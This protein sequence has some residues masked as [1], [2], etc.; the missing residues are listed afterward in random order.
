MIVL[1]YPTSFDAIAGWATENRILLREARIRFAQYGVLRAIGAS[2]QLRQALVFK[3][4]NALDF[5]WHAY[6]STRDLDFSVD[7]DALATP[8]DAHSLGEFL[9][10]GLRLVQ[11]DLGIAFKIHRV[12]KQPPGEGATFVTFEAKVGYALPDEVA[13][14]RRMERGEPSSNIVPVE[15]S[16]NEPICGSTVV[17]LQDANSLR[18]SDVDDIIAEKLRAL[19]QQ[20][21]RN[22]TRRQDLLDIASLLRDGPPIDHQRV[23]DFLLRKAA[24]RDVTVTRRALRDPEIAT[25]AR[26]GYDE[27]ASTTRQPFIPVEEAFG[28]LYRLVDALPIP[29]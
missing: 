7:M 22:R 21:I 13:L 12:K 20:P 28:A 25:R 27:L 17:A 6:R 4:G 23:A 1:G 11:R 24:A 10:G 3:G 18:V 19:L 15:V 16:L 5:V 14:R 29:G 2:A 26:D 9:N 8:L